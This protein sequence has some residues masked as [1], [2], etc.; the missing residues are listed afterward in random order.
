MKYIL[1]AYFLSICMV[2]SSG[3]QN[4]Q[5]Q[6]RTTL[7][8]TLK[9]RINT[10]ADSIAMS[11]AEKI[12]SLFSRPRIIIGRVDV[13]PPV[14]IQPGRPWKSGYRIFWRYLIKGNDT[15]FYN[16]QVKPL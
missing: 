3:K 15:T 1:L 4:N 11:A 7:M 13:I 16:T 12:D 14:P 9:A 2:A 5:Y 6:P 8:D 10:K